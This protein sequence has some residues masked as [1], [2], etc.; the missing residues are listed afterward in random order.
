[1]MAM[2]QDQKGINETLQ[3]H[4]MLQNIVT[5]AFGMIILSSKR[6]FSEKWSEYQDQSFI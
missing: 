2:V 1:M 6:S 5:S 4:G 3:Y